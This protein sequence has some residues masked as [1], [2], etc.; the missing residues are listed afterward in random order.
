ML[1]DGSD[2][3]ALPV[4]D[5]IHVNLHG[6]FQEAVNQHGAFFG[7]FHGF[8]HVP[9]QFFF[10]IYND[11][12]ASA[13]HEGGAQQHRVTDARGNGGGV[14]HIGGCSCLRL[15]QPQFFQQGGK[16]FAV[17]RQVNGPGAGADNRHAV[18]FQR[19]GQVQRRLS[20]EL[21]DDAVRLLLLA[22]MEH[23]FQRQG[24]E[25]KLVGGIIVRG[26]GFRVGVHDDGFVAHFPQS[27]GGV[28]AAVVELNPLANA[29]WAAAQDEDFF[30]ACFAGFIFIS[31]GG[32]KVGGVGFEFRGA[33]IHQPISG[34]NAL[35]LAFLPD[36]F[37]RGSPGQGDL[38]VGKAQLL[39]FPQ[40]QLVQAVSRLGQVLHLCQEPGINLGKL[41]HF[42][43][44]K[45]VAERRLNPENAFCRG[46]SQFPRDFFCGRRLRGLRVKSPAPASRFQGTQGLLQGFLESTTDGHGLPY[47]F[48]GRGQVFV[49]LLEL[50]KREAGNLGNHIVDGGLKAGGRFPRDVIPQFVQRIAYGQFGGQFGNGEPCGLGS[51][52]GR[53]GNAGVHFNDNHAAVGR[54][55]GELDVG[56]A[57]FHADLPDDGK[58]SVPHGLVFSVREGLD[59]GY[60]DGIPGMHAHGVDV[61][62][63][64]NDH[65]IVRAVPHYLHFKFF[66]ADQGLFNQDFGNGGK[67]Q[68]PGAYLLKFRFIVRHAA[69]HA[70]QREGRAD[71]QG[72]GADVPGY[73]ARFLHGVRN[74]GTR[75]VQANAEH[76]FLEQV[77]VLPAVNG[78][79]V[80]A[81]H[82]HL[83]P[84]QHAAAVQF[85]GA[86]QGC[87]PAQGRE[88][89]I[90]FFP[91]DDFL[92]EL[93]SNRFNISAR[94]C[95][96][97][98]HDGGGIG[99]D[100][101]YFITL[102]PEGFAGLGAGV[103]E[104]AAL[105]DDDRAGPDHENL[106]DGGVFRHNG[107]GRIL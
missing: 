80:G 83:F 15:F 68:P 71:N 54:I 2:D 7:S 40:I 104:F 19:I 56:T 18:G 25:E 47:G 86:V 84:F 103:V 35:F 66:P 8:I 79:C 70:A 53:A 11:H 39:G 31:I 73:P 41:L 26:D 24:F 17:F 81:N 44:G 75:H 1:H 21:D 93:R 60:G 48:H 38:P 52:R 22:D 107:D 30:P 27:H 33:G 98:R 49:R 51:Q 76:G 105:A 97:V 5:D 69:S 37:F 74:A 61:L 96:R 63:G 32:I 42:I 13:Q 12:A 59:G 101:H 16:M 23:V 82:T 6:V 89:G 20:S 102:F 91:D 62:N 10:L 94:S 58:R 29:V 67:I 64:A 50:F 88:E 9:A 46:N 14:L 3:G 85:H 65:A 77:A 87:L 99:V 78:V 100:Q 36:V 106:F 57:R 28:H 95:L 92:H 45:S 55:N 72:K 43:Q 34:H 90:R 4:R